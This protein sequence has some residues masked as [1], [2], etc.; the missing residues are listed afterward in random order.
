MSYSM[1]AITITI[2]NLPDLAHAVRRGGCR[3][4]S[5]IHYKQIPTQP[6]YHVPGMTYFL[7][8]YI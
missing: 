5:H 6:H 2:R 7:G 8:R 4:R 3:V 1:V